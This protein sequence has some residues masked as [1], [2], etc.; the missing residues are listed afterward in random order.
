MNAPIIEPAARPDGTR[1]QTE[2]VR[3]RTTAASEWIDPEADDWLAP[4][5]PEPVPEPGSAQPEEGTPSDLGHFW[6]G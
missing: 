1:S 6:F 2:R 4:I 3:A 5:R